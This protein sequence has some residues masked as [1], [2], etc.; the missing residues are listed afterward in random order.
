MTTYAIGDIHGQLD[1][2]RAA[3][4]RIEDDRAR[5]GER[6]APVVHLGDLVDRGPDSRGVVQHLIDGMA[7][8]QDWVVL[9]GNHDRM[10][11]RFLDDPAAAEPGLRSDLSWLHPRL[12]GGET[13]ASYGVH[14]AADRPVVPVHAEARARV[15][16][17]HRAWLTERPAYY[18]RE[19]AVFVHAGIRPGVAIEDQD[20]TDLVWIRGGFLD[21]PRDHGALIVHGHTAIDAAEH[22]GNRLNLDSGAAYGG[23]LSAVAI[24]GRRAWLLCA[25]GRQELLPARAP[26]GRWRL[27]GR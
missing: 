22:Y 6:E 16:A 25:G 8:G 12:G 4:A 9:L 2:L 3:H 18:R 26:A 11:T 14:A 20:E 21:D 15:S 5:E 19:E 27:W 24:E 7:A 13:L 1:L 10:F 23:P 17:M